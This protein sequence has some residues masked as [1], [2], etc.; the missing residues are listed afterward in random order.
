MGRRSLLPVR[1]KTR[2]HLVHRLGA[3][4]PGELANVLRVAETVLIFVYG[5]TS[6]AVL[7]RGYGA[8]SAAVLTFGYGATSAA[9]LTF[10]YGATRA[11]QRSTQSNRRPGMSPMPLRL[12]P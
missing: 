9:V 3:A 10:G 12:S 5:T 2:V 7:S 6:A 11:H 8:T 4:V 1:E